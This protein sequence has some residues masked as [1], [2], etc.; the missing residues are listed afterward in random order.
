MSV[1]PLVPGTVGQHTGC[2]LVKVGQ[3]LFRLAEDDLASLGLRVRHYSILQA[4]A[5]NGSMSQL[6]LGGYLRIDPATMVSSL[7]DLETADYAARAR[8]PRDRRRHVVQITPAGRGV[9]SHINRRLLGGDERAL[10]DLSPAE[11]RALHKALTK[12]STGPTLPAMFDSVRDQTGSR[13]QTGRNQT[14]SRKMSSARSS[15]AP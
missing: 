9:L 14:G 8:D 4:L 5:D 10:A 1:T 15:V 3:V 7:D 6:S 2:L 13:N 11:L 12:L